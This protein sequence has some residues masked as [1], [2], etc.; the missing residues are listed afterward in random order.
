MRKYLFAGAVA[1]GLLLLGATPADAEVVP[2]PAGQ[3]QDGNGV[4]GLLDGINNSL[5]DS[6]VLDVTPGDNSADLLNPAGSVLP[7]KGA[8][9][10]ARTGLGKPTDRMPAGAAGSG[11]P[12]TD[13]LGRGLPG[14]G[15]G[16]SSLPLADLLSGGGGLL[17][18][19]PAGG[20]GLPLAGGGLPTGGSGLPT[21]SS[22]PT[23]SGLQ[24]PGGRAATAGG[25]ESSV[26]G[27]EMSLLGGL[28][29]LDGLLPYSSARTLPAAS[30]MPAGG[31]AVPA[32]ADQAP[33]TVT[34]EK[35]SAKPAVQPAAADPATGADKRLHEEPIDPEGAT[36]VRKFSEGRPVAGPDTEYR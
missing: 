14:V 36:G 30:G 19:L 8:M 10:A 16:L 13:R 34:P 11:L 4:G 24:I 15:G 17:S 18:G 32:P 20:G 1:G 27:D 25:P 6:N 9:P 12:A 22:L 5:S 31:T 28:G 7:E 3:Q 23:G 33:V 2:A 29:G 26:L 21:G 35:P